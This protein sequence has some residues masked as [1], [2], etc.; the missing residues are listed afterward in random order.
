MFDMNQAISSLSFGAQKIFIYG[1]P[2]I[3]KTTFSSTFEAPFILKTEDGTEAVDI[4]TFPDENGRPAL[5]RDFISFDNAL[6]AFV[7]QQHDF[8][9]LII[10]SADWLEPLVWSHVA[11]RMGKTSIEEIGYGKGYIEADTE[12]RRTL[13][14]FDLVIERGINVVIIAHS[15]IKSVNPPGAEAFDRYQIK[16]HKR[17]SAFFQ[18]WATMI[19]FCKYKTITLKEESGFNK[20]RAYATGNGERALYTEERPAHL[21]GNRFGLPY[22]IHIGQDNT[23]RPFHEALNKATDN[24]YPIPTNILHQGF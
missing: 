4:P 2:K 24:R 19:L 20:T 13:K 18:E 1:V 9:T 15:E 5:F 22:E 10:D 17:A 3:G 6:A 23:W 8:K 21:G 12:W 14:W 7:Q 16:L 11:A